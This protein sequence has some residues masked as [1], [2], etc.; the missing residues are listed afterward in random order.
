MTIKYG[1]IFHY[2]ARQKIPKLG[3]LVLKNIPKLGFLVLK[4]IPKLGFLV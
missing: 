3:F 4:N 1:N 2:K